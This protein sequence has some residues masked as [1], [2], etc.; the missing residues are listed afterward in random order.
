M[1]FQL[2]PL[3]LACAML[4]HAAGVHAQEAA[5]KAADT[6]TLEAVTITAQ[7]RSEVLSKAPLAVSV[8][9]QKALD[10]QG[11]T[12]LTDIASSVPNMAVASNGFSMRGIGS[13]ASFGG[14]STVAVHVD[15]IYEPNYQVLS[16]GLYDVGRIEALRGP[17]GTV[18]GRNATVGVV[19]VITARPTAR[20]QLF[21]DV[22]YGDHN[23]VTAR[24][25]VNVPVSETLLLRASALRRTSDG[26]EPGRAVS[27]RYGKVDLSSARLAA[28]WQL[29][30]SLKW[31]VS[32][33][34]LE[35]KGTIAAVHSVAYNYF[36]DANIA[37]G[38]L[39]KRVTVPVDTNV[40][41]IGGG[42]A[43]TGIR[44]DLTQ[45]GLR[46]SLV[47]AV[48]DDW[49]VTYLAG[50]TKLVNNGVDLNS[51]IFSLYNKD[52]KTITRSHELNVNY[53][54][55][56]LKLVGGLYDYRDEQTGL[57]GVRIGNA[58]PA[59]LAGVLPQGL[60]FAPGAGNLPS[61]YGNLDAAVR[62]NALKNTSR[63][64]FGQATYSV[65]DVWRMTLGLRGTRD[66][67][68][69]DTDTQAC[70]YGTMQALAANLPCGV[71]FGPAVNASGTTSS[72]NTS[73][74]VTSEF[75]LSKTDMLYATVSTGYRGGGVTPNV[76]TP[77]LTYKPETLTS[78]EAGW[79]GRL[80]GDTLGLN[81]TAF[82][83][84]YKDLQVSTIGKNLSGNNTVV[85][86][87][88]ATARV[89]GIEAE[90]DWR[91]TRQDHLQG[92]LTL[93]DAKFGTVAPGIDNA[94]AVDVLYNNFAPTPINTA[95][96]D[97]SGR[98]LPNAPKISARLR[99]AHTIELGANGQWTPSIQTY[100]QSGSHSVIDSLSSTDPLLGYRKA[101]S[102]TDLNLDWQS[103]DRRWN[104]NA[105]VYNAE[106]RQVYT[107]NTQI[108]ALS[109]ASYMPRRTFG[110]RVGYTFY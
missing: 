32:L 59:P 58:L 83:M 62:N 23:D 107:S 87:N 73:Y 46:S 21:G 33:S 93:L 54:S 2:T 47:W 15:G 37:A 100:W 104:V 84:D 8:V 53:E 44:K 40:G 27:S 17:Q 28:A 82:S 20:Q 96:L 65:S 67:A 106:D 61:G 49:T 91:V 7:R 85:T 57:Y 74:K 98:R 13:N 71:P 77:Y 31:N 42:G 56:R 101:Y 64:A 18:Y 12:S 102:K 19:N 75:D 5:A 16:L 39:G 55:D 92:F 26:D 66:T 35:D 80:R 4:V 88:A 9:S 97:N 90:L 25:V 34:K 63:A 22:S 69:T 29:G 41:G 3:S 24:A 89:R 95:P 76:A 86:G 6:G 36:P 1:K 108:L 30:D 60:A 70:Q 105:H 72:R 109:I 103:Q 45:T 79:R 11:I 51:G 99:Y 50:L 38:T 110:L 78:F 43:G 14:Y 94:N 81:L 10:A 48:N 52:N 68:L